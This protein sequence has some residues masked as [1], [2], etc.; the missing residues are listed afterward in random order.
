MKFTHILVINDPLNP[1]IESLTR[2]QLWN[3]LLLRVESPKMFVPWL[4]SC[5]VYDRTEDG[6][7]RE[8]RYGEL[9]ILDR[10]SFT[11]QERIEI[12]VPQQKDIPAST[13][14]MSIEEP[15]PGILCVRFEYDDGV[16]EVEGSMDAF[17]N[18]FRQSAYKESDIDTVGIIRQLAEQGR[19]DA[20]YS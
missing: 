1:L 2:T 15:Q 14:V 6:L 11:P 3:G 10:A 19:L 12:Q 18:E 7:S 16:E 20:R 8:Q 17:Y 4:D 13:L 9:T 5:R